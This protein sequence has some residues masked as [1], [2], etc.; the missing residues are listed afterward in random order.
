MDSDGFQ[1]TNVYSIETIKREEVIITLKEVYD[2]LKERGYKPI[3]QL[4]GYLMSGDLAYIS[5][6]KDARKKIAV[7]SREDIIETLLKREL[8]K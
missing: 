8:E 6:Y 4:V 5:S 1:K 3:N 7:I 2:A